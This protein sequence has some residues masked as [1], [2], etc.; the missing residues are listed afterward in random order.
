MT[1]VDSMVIFLGEDP[2]VVPMVRNHLEQISFMNLI[3]LG[4]RKQS[5]KKIVRQGCQ[6]ETKSA[7][8]L[9]DNGLKKEVELRIAKLET[10]VKVE[11]SSTIEK[12]DAMEVAMGMMVRSVT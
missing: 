4:T 3:M 2:T 9:D 5:A 6:R 7:H 12:L 10:M 1:C 11:S 8:T